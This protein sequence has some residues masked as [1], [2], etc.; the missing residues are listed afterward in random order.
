MV[1]FY[2]NLTWIVKKFPL[3]SDINSNVQIPHIC[4]MSGK[5]VGWIL[6]HGE[7]RRE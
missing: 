7:G 3:I 2:I 6:K 5:W 1:E 4:K